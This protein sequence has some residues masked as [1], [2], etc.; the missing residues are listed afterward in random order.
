MTHWWLEKPDGSK[1]DPTAAQFSPDE[2]KKAYSN[3]K[4]GNFGL[5]WRKDASGKTVQ[6]PSSRAKIIMDRVGKKG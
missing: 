3:G 6:A 2:L 5:G 4:D 1:V